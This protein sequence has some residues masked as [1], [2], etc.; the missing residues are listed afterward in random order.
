MKNTKIILGPPGT[1][2]TTTLLNIVDKALADGVKSECIGYVSFTRKAANEAKVRAKRKFGKERGFK[3]FRTLHSMAYAQIGINRKQVMTKK[4]LINF[5]YVMNLE[6][7]DGFEYGE[8]FG[9][10]TTHDDKVMAMENLARIT[11]RPL[12]DVVHDSEEL[13]SFEETERVREGLVKYKQAEGVLDFTDFIYKAIDQDTSPRFDLLVVDEAQDL[14]RL[15]WKYV[16]KLAARSKNVYIAGDDDQAIFKWNGADLE[17]FQSIDA[18]RETLHQS[19]RVPQRIHYLASKII[20]QVDKRIDKF[21][22][23]RKKAEGE[24]LEYGSVDQLALESGNWYILARNDYL[25]HEVKAFC[26]SMGFYYSYKGRDCVKFEIL[27]AIT[28]WERYRKGEE[29]KAEL[30][31][32]YMKEKK[33]TPDSFTHYEGVDKEENFKHWYDALDNIPPITVD[34]IRGMLRNE[35]DLLKEPRIHISTIH[36]VKGGEA[37]NVALITD[38]ARKT[39]EKYQEFPDDEHRVFYV[40]ITRARKTLHLIDAQTT[41]CYDLWS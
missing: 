36:G 9:M 40:A 35:E 14:S 1:G 22:K 3:Y 19:Y 30:F 21:W 32:P 8:M 6:L 26:E 23:P 7:S 29:F 24:I 12:E 25:L 37:D 4:H 31:I 33:L 34:Y 5:A 11:M 39:F 18:P 13:I 16:E 38:M 20:L 15:Q 27:Q 2:K 28:E 10:G 41:M 17:Y